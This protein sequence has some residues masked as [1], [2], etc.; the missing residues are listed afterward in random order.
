MQDV[1]FSLIDNFMRYAKEFFYYIKYDCY[2]SQ[3]TYSM[4]F[5]KFKLTI[6]SS[7]ISMMNKIYTKFDN[8]QKIDNTL[9]I[10]YTNYDDVKYPSQ[11][12]QTKNL[13]FNGMA[14]T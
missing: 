10:I 6:N 8:M 11:K 5:L 3:S 14:T 7:I 13:Y 2:H 12:S 4:K 1:L 9:G